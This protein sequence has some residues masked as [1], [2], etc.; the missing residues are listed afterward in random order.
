M[1]SRER[2]L[3]A[4][5]HQKVDRVPTDI[6]A[7][8]EVKTMLSDKFGSWVNALNALHIDGMYSVGPNYIGPPLPAMPDN[9]MVDFWGM[10]LRQVDYGTGTYL[11]QYHF[12]LAKAGNVDDLNHYTWPKADW[13]DFSDMPDLLQ[14][15][16]EKQVT[17]CGYMAPFYYHNLLRGLEAS[18]V[19][20]FD[21]PEFTHHLLN[22]ISDFFFE[23]HYRMFETCKGLID[24]AQV[25]D[26]FGSQ[27]G[28][29]ISRDTFREFYKPQTKRFIDLCRSF[30]VIVFHHDDGSIRPILP[31]LLEMGIDILNP[32]QWTCPGMELAG[33]KHDFGKEICFHGGIDNQKILPFGTHEDVRA[34]VRHNIDALASDGTAY[35][36]APCHNLQPVT[37][38]E[39]IIAMYDEA[40]NYGKF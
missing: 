32:I 28:L 14:K 1:K 33:L 18:L 23:Y 12:P 24:I 9:E 22:K 31:E 3:A 38:M 30:D 40:W 10:R 27:A 13:F 34:E 4:I 16:G 35:I 36:L 5:H 7:T 19:D 20:P 2:M 8:A 11:E 15:A 37:P 25:T 6:W 21:D 29:M 26:D 17:L 39:N